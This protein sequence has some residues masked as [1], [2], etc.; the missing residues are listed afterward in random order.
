LVNSSLN[1]ISP[2]LLAAVL[3]DITVL[4]PAPLPVSLGCN[5][6][7]LGTNHNPTSATYTSFLLAPIWFYR[8]R[9]TRTLVVKTQADTLAQNSNS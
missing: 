1:L 7:D 9:P 4:I 5:S 8:L 2:A 6:A 3:P